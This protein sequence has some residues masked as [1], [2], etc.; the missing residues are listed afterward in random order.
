MVNIDL[1]I[2]NAVKDWLNNRYEN[3]VK[4]PIERKTIE[5]ESFITQQANKTQAQ[6]NKY[7]PVNYYQA[8]PIFHRGIFWICVLILI[9]MWIISG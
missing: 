5:L 7:N 6:A 9:V 1:G 8:K 4:Q 2:K 3:W